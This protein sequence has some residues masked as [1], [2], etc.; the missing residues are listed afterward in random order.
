MWKTNSNV[1]HSLRMSSNNV[2]KVAD[3][4]SYKSNRIFRHQKIQAFT[5]HVWIFTLINLHHN[6]L[7][8]QKCYSLSLILTTHPYRYIHTHK[9]MTASWLS[10]FEQPTRMALKF[11]ALIKLTMWLNLIKTPQNIRSDMVFILIGVL[12]K[13]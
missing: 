1:H 13:L 8:M 6:L 3:V 5:W 10:H 4:F 11:S 9:M 12:N 2:R 7:F